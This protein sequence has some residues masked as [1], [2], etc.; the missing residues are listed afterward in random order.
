MLKHIRRFTVTAHSMLIAG[1]VKHFGK[2]KEERVPIELTVAYK[3]GWGLRAEIPRLLSERDYNAM[4][5]RVM[6]VERYRWERG[7]EGEAVLIVFCVQASVVSKIGRSKLEKLVQD[8]AVVERLLQRD[9]RTSEKRAEEMTK[10]AEV[11]AQ[12]LGLRC[13]NGGAAWI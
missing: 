4:R 9:S 13:R 7:L 6:E 3:P 12:R 5:K 10:T 2:G 1:P 8:K 11:G